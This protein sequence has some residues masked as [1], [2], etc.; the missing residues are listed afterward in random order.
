MGIYH[1]DALMAPKSVTVV[2]ARPRERSLGRIALRN[3]REG[4]FTYPI[5]LVNPHYAEVDGVKAV[6]SFDAIGTPPQLRWR[7]SNG[8]PVPIRVLLSGP[9]QNTGSAAPRPL[10]AGTC[11]CGLFARSTKS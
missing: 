6:A 11:C 9:I 8:P 7:R 5:H 4:G 10:T 3:L 1:L 2:G